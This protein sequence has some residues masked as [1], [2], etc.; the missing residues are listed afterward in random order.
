MTL[1]LLA[2][3][4]TEPVSLDAFK[5]HLRVTHTDEDP[6]IAGVLA[7]ATRAI[8]ARTGLAL[9]PQSWR[10]TVDAVPEE[11]LLLPVAP[12]VRIDAVS[13]TGPDGE[14]APVAA[15]RY[16]FAPGSPGRLRRA[17]PWPRVGPAMDG[18]RIDFTA[19]YDEG[20]APAPL[21][22]AVKALAA[23]FYE[24]RASVSGERPYSTPQSVDALIA[25]YAQVRL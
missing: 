7:A 17:A 25:P 4:A 1:I 13:V 15:S 21:L 5:S 9:S 2:S 19:G 18:V 16:E 14:T 12:C 24:T 6:L 23:H 11:T 20:A 3:A 22:Q 8:E 10:M